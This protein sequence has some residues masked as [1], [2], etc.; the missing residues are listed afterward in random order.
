MVSTELAKCSPPSIGLACGLGDLRWA[1]VEIAAKWAGA[2]VEFESHGLFLL[3][4]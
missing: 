3:L 4:V 2:G 1:L